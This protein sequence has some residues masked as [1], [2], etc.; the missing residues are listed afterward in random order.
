MKK[1]RSL[2]LFGFGLL[3]A[4]LVGWTS[5]VTSVSAD[6]PI[7]LRQMN[8]TAGNFVIHSDID[9]AHC[10]EA[11]VTEVAQIVQPPNPQKVVLR[12]ITPPRAQADGGLK[13]MLMG[14]PQLD[15]FPEAKNAF[16]RAAAIWEAIIQTPITIILNV[17]F[18]PTRF[19]TPFPSGVLGSTGSQVV[20]ADNIFP[21]IREGLI[22][23]EPAGT[24][25]S[26]LYNTL[27]PDR[28]TTDLGPTG[29]IFSPATVFRAL[30]IL[31]PVA[32]P[33]MESNLGAVPSIGFNSNFEFDFDPNDGINISQI[34]FE[35]TAVHEI[36]HALGFTSSVG[37]RELNPNTTIGTSIWDIFRFRPGVSAMTF[38]S[39]Q[40]I[41]SSGGDQ[42]FF[43]GG[44]P[45]PLSTGRPNASGGDGA[46]SS[47]WKATRF[48]GTRIGIMDPFLGRG[49]R[50]VVTDNDRLAIDA[51]G[52]TVGASSPDFRLLLNT[53]T[54]EVRA[55]ESTNF[56]LD[57]M[58]VGGFAQ[59]VNFNVTSS[60]NNLTTSLSANQTTAG[61]PITLTV[62]PA[63]NAPMETATLTITA[64][65]GSIVRTVTATVNIL[66]NAPDF[67][68][69]FDVVNFAVRRGQRST[70]NVLVNRLNNFDGS[71]TISAPNASSIKT[72]I[73][74]ASMSTTGSSVPFTFRV[75]KKAPVGQQQ[76]T[77]TA[78]DAN[79]R[80]RSA[81]TTLTI[82]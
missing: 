76:L 30:K 10:Q 14:T 36:G 11:S 5:P 24:M 62:T 50:V 51:F 8:Q 53:P 12:P 71:V 79:G 23:S 75:K 40:R 81:T 70:I 63:A 67:T 78:V 59:T 74:P 73:T 35:A 31:P 19:G 52:Y 58:A 15:R 42:I 17:D 43:V 61:S 56:M 60:S 28:L 20:G 6:E 82:Q 37:S 45:I 33:M 29:V 66:S 2:I 16:I 39:A 22:E 68:L 72:T 7:K 69:G 49:E 65:S 48:V 26:N 4:L 57:V 80:V 44:T 21:G 18:G 55:G 25:L 46:Q 64:T 9:G 54:Q 27:P 77:F 32:N 41:L 34:D 47:H 38:G 13:I 1:Y 3:L